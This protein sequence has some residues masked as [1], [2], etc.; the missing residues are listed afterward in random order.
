MTDIREQIPPTVPREFPERREPSKTYGHR[1]VPARLLPFETD[2]VFGDWLEIES[3]WPIDVILDSSNISATRGGVVAW[4]TSDVFTNGGLRVSSSF[5][6]VPWSKLRIEKRFERLRISSRFPTG[7]VANDWHYAQVDIRWGRLTEL[8]RSGLRVPFSLNADGAAVDAFGF[9]NFV[10]IPFEMHDGAD[11]A[12]VRWL[13]SEVELHSVALGQDNDKSIESW[14]LYWLS[15]PGPQRTIH[16]EE[17]DRGTAGALNESKSHVTTHLDP[18]LTLRPFQGDWNGGGFGL[19]VKI[20][21]GVV[22]D[23]IIPFRL[24]CHARG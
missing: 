10:P 12:G 3:T 20:G 11:A 17:I 1:V 5:T 22:G 13:P 8:H 15:T 23:F 14:R 19:E 7:G 21:N 24:N 6:V 4:D 9:A 16:F 18:P 2:D